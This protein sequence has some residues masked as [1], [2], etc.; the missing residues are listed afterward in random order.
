MTELGHVI[1]EYAQRQIGQPE[2]SIL[3][4]RIK[5]RLL[6]QSDRSILQACSTTPSHRPI[7]APDSKGL[8]YIPS[9]LAHQNIPLTH[10]K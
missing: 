8:E 1:E 10:L 9:P 5:I 4:A 6:N 3:Q 2:Q 7:R